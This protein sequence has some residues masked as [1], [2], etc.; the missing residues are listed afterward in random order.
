MPFD[1]QYYWLAFKESQKKR[2]TCTF[3]SIVKGVLYDFVSP[4]SSF[5]TFYFL[6]VNSS[7]ILC[8]LVYSDSNPRLHHILNPIVQTRLSPPMLGF[9]FVD[10]W[11]RCSEWSS[12]IIGS[13]SVDS[14][15]FTIQ[16]KPIGHA[17]SVIVLLVRNHPRL[18]RLVTIIPQHSCSRSSGCH[19]QTRYI[20]SNGLQCF[21]PTKNPI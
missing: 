8:I 17:C 1:V 12:T 20:Y 18:F 9:Y 4:S 16:S 11:T 6:T 14:A 2:N 10:K 15:Q 3:N 7:L 19:N 13:A 21:L 5:H